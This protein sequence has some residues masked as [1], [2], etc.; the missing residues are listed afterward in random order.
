M[1]HTERLPKVTCR[2]VLTLSERTTLSV[3][4]IMNVFL[5]FIHYR[6]YTDDIDI[7]FKPNLFTRTL[8]FLLLITHTIKISYLHEIYR[9]LLTLSGIPATRPVIEMTIPTSVDR[10][11][12]P[13]GTRRNFYFALILLLFFPPF[14]YFLFFIFY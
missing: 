5:C 3:L 14:F 8:L 7:H 11:V 4:L 1:K 2:T 10:T 6:T 13:E 12:A 9:T